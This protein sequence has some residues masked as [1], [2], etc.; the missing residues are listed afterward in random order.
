LRIASEVGIE[1]ARVAERRELRRRELRA[2]LDEQLRQLG[3]AVIDGEEDRRDVVRG[4]AE[5]RAIVVEKSG[6]RCGVVVADGGEE[7]VGF[8]RLDFI[9]RLYLAERIAAPN[10]PPAA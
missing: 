8:H 2:A 10:Q 3:V 5:Q 1:C 9:A 6:D 7:L 4:R